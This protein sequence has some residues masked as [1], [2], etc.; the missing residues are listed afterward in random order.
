M[1]KRTLLATTA[2]TAFAALTLAVSP[3]FAGQGNPM[4]VQMAQTQGEGSAGATGAQIQGRMQGGGMMGGQGQGMMGDKGMMG[5]QGMMGGGTMARRRQAMR[6]GIPAPYAS[7]TDP[8]PRSPETL[9]RGATV[10]EDNCASCHGANGRGD[11]EAGRDLSPLPADLSMLSRMRMGQWDAFMYW[12]VAEGGEPFGT[13]MP[14]FKEALE[15]DEIWA[16]ISYLQAGL[17]AR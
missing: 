10:Y 3:S 6:S 1:I 15:P 2:A 11:G 8:L 17:P 7:M 12:A 13:A 9:A 4:G 5:G 16:A 14:A